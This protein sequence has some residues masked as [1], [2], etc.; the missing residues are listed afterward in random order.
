MQ[1]VTPNIRGAFGPVEETLGIFP[2]GYL[3]GSRIK[4]PGAGG[5]PPDS[6]AGEYGPTRPNKEGPRELNSFLC[7][8]R[9]SCCSIKGTGGVLD[10]IPCHISQRGD[11]ISAEAEFHVG[12]GGNGRDPRGLPLPSRTP[13]AAGGKDGGMADGTAVHSQRDGNECTGMAVCPLPTIGPRVP[14]PTK[15]T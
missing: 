12:R 9:T 7:H 6:E 3:L 14:R 15:I 1:Q 2:T 11:R 13:L 10:G 8:H 5:H 4:D